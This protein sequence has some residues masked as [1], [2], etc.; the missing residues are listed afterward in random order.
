M[1][2]L[3]GLWGL[4]LLSSSLTQLPFPGSQETLSVQRSH[5]W[6]LGLLG[7]HHCA[8][9]WLH[10]PRAPSGPWPSLPS[11]ASVQL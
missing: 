1:K 4:P 11:V 2:G 5:R 7:S 8:G 9:P 10:R 3:H 6:Q